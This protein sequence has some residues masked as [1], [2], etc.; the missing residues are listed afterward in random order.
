MELI[1][2]EIMRRDVETVTEDLPLPDLEQRFVSLGVGGFP[3]L[4]KERLVGIVSRIDIVRR[5]CLERDLARSVSDFYRDETGFHELPVES[6][7]QMAERVGERIE[8]LCV[9]DVMH[10]QLFCVS[11]QAPVRAVAETMADHHIHRVLVTADHRL[12]GIITALDLVRLC[13]NGRL[14]P[15]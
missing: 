1:A 15:G 4:E 11:P 6:I 12:V 7:T 8:H 13:A 2:R 14:R 9:R 5:L 3:V 10:R